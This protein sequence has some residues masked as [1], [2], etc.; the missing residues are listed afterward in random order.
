MANTQHRLRSST[1]PL[2]IESGDLISPEEIASKIENM[3]LT[4]EGT[5]RSTWGPA[6]Y[7]PQYST[8]MPLYTGPLK[9][10]HHAVIGEEGS[11][12]ILLIQDGSSLKVFDGWAAGPGGHANVWRSLINPTG[13]GADLSDDFGADDKPRFPAQF[14]TTPTGIVIIPSGDNSRPYFYDGRTILPLGYSSAP[15]A[16]VGHG[17]SSLGEFPFVQFGATNEGGSQAGYARLGSMDITVVDRADKGRIKEGHWFGAYQWTDIWGNLSPLSGKSETLEIP[18]SEICKF[19]PGGGD[20][21][22]RDQKYMFF[23]E[24]IE[25]GPEGT[26]GRIFCR[27]KDVL[28]SGT[29][30]MFRIPAGMI[31]S[32]P[33]NLTS[34]DPTVRL[35]YTPIPDNITT[36]LPDNI[37]DDA[38]IRRPE[39][40]VAV[41]PFKLYA[42]AFGRGWAA[43]FADDPG[44][45][46]PSIPGKWGTFRIDEEIY[47]DPRGAAITGMFQ[48]PDG[49]LV[50]TSES[51]F[52]VVISYSGEG[53]QTK[54]IHPRIGC[55]A[56]SS[57]SMMP[58]GKAIW[59]GREGFYSYSGG[60][61]ELIS[62]AIHREVG[63]F[64]SARTIQSVAA[65]D[66]HE[67]KYRCWVPMN[68]SRQNNVCWEY[69]GSGWT[70]RNDVN[71]SAVCVTQ[72]HRRYMIAV[73][74]TKKKSV[75]NAIPGVYLLDHQIQ[76]F[77][78]EDRAS[79]IQTS[80]LRTFRS[81]GRGSPTTVYLWLR[82]SGSGTV[83]VE[84]ERDWREGIV[85]TVTAKTYP[86]DDIPPFWDQAAY[87]ASDASGDPLTWKN[88]RPYW[89]RVDIFSPSSETFRLR[90]TNTVPW[91]FLGLAFDEVPRPDT[92]R[93]APK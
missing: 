93:S 84:V 73:G 83:T 2:R 5:L 6:P 24:G 86:A 38:L 48:V 14:E 54:T 16:C 55:I 39:E 4:D 25:P 10:V 9:G 26:V 68:G 12:E 36:T 40:V 35:G 22:L 57:V 71:A 47:P 85:E 77:D 60:N 42:L 74:E 19:S 70:R 63:S 11:R 67:Q 29:A 51:T 56:P 89:T 65:F 33:L 91:E 44:K 79:M 30:E 34:P 8:G 13:T 27:T 21:V 69:D 49:L 31:G 81:E 20:P 37:P 15:G 64:N 90:I 53:F 88:R 75:A 23:W 41:R 87:G 58:D 50:F 1:L 78:P 62:N 32:G 46:H 45:I 7:V 82:E 72:D 92:F 17:P 61:I 3:Y 59:L 43:N 76:S 18:L 80:W 52:L 66:V 28:N